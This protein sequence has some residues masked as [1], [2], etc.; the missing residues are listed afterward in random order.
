M[1]K[2]ALALIRWRL[3]E[4]HN[5]GN[6]GDRRVDNAEGAKTKL[7]SRAN[8]DR[9]GSSRGLRLSA[10]GGVDDDCGVDAGADGCGRADR[11]DDDVGC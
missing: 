2:R 11:G 5:C 3:E 9:T 8:N 4:A 6:D 10:A 1:G 7:R